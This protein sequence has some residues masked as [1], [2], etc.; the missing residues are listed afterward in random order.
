MR[1]PP[2]ETAG[3]HAR[4]LDEAA[5]LFREQ[6]LVGPGVAEVMGAAG[7]THGAFY[8]H[9]PSKSALVSEA[10]SIAFA[11]AEGRI[12]E[13][14]ASA[15][16]PRQ[17]FLDDYL[18]SQHRDR[19]G[20]GC[21]LAALGSELSRQPECRAIVTTHFKKLLENMETWF[22]DY[23]CSRAE[24]IQL[25]ASAIG[26]LILARA[27]NETELSDEVM[28]AVRQLARPV[29]REPQRVTA[30]RKIRSKRLPAAGPTATPPRSR[31]RHISKAADR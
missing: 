2:E 19:P 26:A 13:A 11:Q 16:K 4:I 29:E 31:K 30:P 6:G 5:R 7:L 28:A 24:N 27:V 14:V 8:A 9:F 23:P 1:Y 25:L 15:K 10:L 18:S 12:A 21:P 3:K 22:A 20:L 17:A